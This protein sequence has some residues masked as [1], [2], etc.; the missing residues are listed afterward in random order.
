MKKTR[1]HEFL[2]RE[3][4]VK[5]ADDYYALELTEMHYDADRDMLNEYVSVLRV[6]LDGSTM[7]LF[8]DHNYYLTYPFASHETFRAHL[9][10]LLSLMLESNRREIKQSK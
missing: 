8:I 6:E 10:R 4:F 9:M 2:E 7:H 3:G 1:A 5:E